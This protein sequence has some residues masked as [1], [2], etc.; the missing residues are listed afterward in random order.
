MDHGPLDQD[1]EVSVDLS[2]PQVKGEFLLLA[3]SNSTATSWTRIKNAKNK[4]H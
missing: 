2:R 4:Q 1:G 3:I